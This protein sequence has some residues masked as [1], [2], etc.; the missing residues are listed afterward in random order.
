MIRPAPPEAPAPASLPASGFRWRAVLGAGAIGTAI[1]F[2]LLV[3][4]EV[5][6]SLTWP[7]ARLRRGRGRGRRGCGAPAAPDQPGLESGP[8][9]GSIPAGW[10]GAA[11]AGGCAIIPD[12]ARRLG[13]P[14]P[15][16]ADVDRLRPVRRLGP[17]GTSA[18]RPYRDLP[19]FDFPARSTCSG[20][21]AACSA[22]R[23]RALYAF[24]AACLGLL[25]LALNARASALGGRC[26]GWSARCSSP[27]TWAGYTRRWPG[28]QATLGG[29]RPDGAGLARRSGRIARPRRSGP[30]RSAA[31]GRLLAALAAAV[32]AEVPRRP[33]ARGP[34]AALAE[35]SAAA[36]W[37]PSWPL[38]PSCWQAWRGV[39]FASCIASYGASQ[40]H[41][42]G[43]V[44]DGP[45]R[46][47]RGLGARGSSAFL[48]LAPSA[49]ADPRPGGPGASP[50]SEPWPTSR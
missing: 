28:W 31:A 30:W 4:P 8:R 48:L 1:L 9:R 46:A 49:R 40:P 21:S 16:L 34:T 26:P 7:G 20:P 25:G 17:R 14:L 24:D 13:A 35:W 39:S 6:R 45:D 50:W 19:D 5:Y 32:G 38:A 33:D 22:G 27:S 18:L 3:L 41:D 37:R 12:P 42:P 10:V 29:R 43:S 11:P 44:L 15:H 47:A 23:H 2:G 36:G